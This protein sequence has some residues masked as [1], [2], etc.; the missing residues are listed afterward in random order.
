MEVR[1]QKPR[2]W[3]LVKFGQYTGRAPAK[4]HTRI[5]FGFL[6]PI[7]NSNMILSGCNKKKGAHYFS[8]LPFFFFT[9]L[10]SIFPKRLRHL[11]I[12]QSIGFIIVDEL[13]LIRIELQV[14]V[15]LHSY[16]THIN[17]GT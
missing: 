12:S 14:P 15:Q 3:T 16:L 1:N 10:Q 8:V 2:L 7:F 6:M 4:G 13:L 17:H 5:F 9:D 11:R